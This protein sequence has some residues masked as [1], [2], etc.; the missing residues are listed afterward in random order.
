MKFYNSIVGNKYNKYIGN[1]YSKKNETKQ[2]KNKQDS[3]I[4]HIKYIYK[5]YFTI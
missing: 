3:T 4:Q 1:M 2:H 5:V